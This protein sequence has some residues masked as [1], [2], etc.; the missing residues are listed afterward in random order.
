MIS[1]DPVLLTLERGEE[2]APGF[3][4]GCAAAR[5]AA[6]AG[7]AVAGAAA[8]GSGSAATRPGQTVA[9]G[10]RA[11]ARS[12]E[13]GDARAVIVCTDGVPSAVVQHL[14]V[15][16]TL[17]GVPIAMLA[18]SP[19]SLADAVAPCARRRGR[20]PGSAVAVALLQGCSRFLRCIFGGPGLMMFQPTF[21]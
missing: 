12:V 1:A 15:L 9:V 17:R 10:L 13:R 8:D 18:S 5:A 2:A 7:E 19:G 3:R 20:G 16:C 14:P 11:T 21:A 6:T 4:S